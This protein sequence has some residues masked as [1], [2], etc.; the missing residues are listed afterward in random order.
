MEDFKL[1]VSKIMELMSIEIP[2][3]GQR[4]S[5]LMIVIG[6]TILSLVIG[7]VVRIFG[8]E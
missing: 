2:I 1:I 4:I 6:F 3:L 7:F 8:G 5:I